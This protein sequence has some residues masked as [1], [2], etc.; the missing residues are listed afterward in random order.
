MIPTRPKSAFLAL[1]LASTSA[2]GLAG[3][4]AATTLIHR[5]QARQIGELTEVVL[6]RSEFA[7][8]FGA[9]SLDQLASRG[10]HSAGRADGR[11]GDCL[12]RLGV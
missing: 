5:Q 8:D 3:H 9:A 6:R 10:R 11:A 2:F 1:V 4:I 7:V 12:P